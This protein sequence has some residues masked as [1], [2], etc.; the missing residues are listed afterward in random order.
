MGSKIVY[1]SDQHAPNF[2][3]RMFFEVLVLDRQDRVVEYLWKIVILRD[4]AT[5]E[6]EGPKRAA[7][8]VI[9]YGVRNRTIVPRS[10]SCG[11]SRE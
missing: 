11:R 4:D 5:L 3:S 9:E 8:V 10:W 2:K 1:G 6:G 7:L